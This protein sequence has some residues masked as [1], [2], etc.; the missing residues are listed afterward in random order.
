MNTFRSADVSARRRY[1]KLAETAKRGGADVL[2]FSDMHVSGERKRFYLLT[3]FLQSWSKYLCH[4]VELQQLSGIAAI[5]KF[6]LPELD[7]LEMQSRSE[8]S[9]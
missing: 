8:A 3:F 4:P 2:I 1:V 7:D 5:L 9:H 6:P